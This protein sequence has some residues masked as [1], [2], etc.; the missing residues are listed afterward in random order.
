MTKS[1]EAESGLGASKLPVAFCC[2]LFG[3]VGSVPDVTL[4]T[5]PFA[6]L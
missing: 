6:K 4:K 5:N 2:A 3:F 1:T